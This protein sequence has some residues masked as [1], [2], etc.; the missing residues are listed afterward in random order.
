MTMISV[1]LADIVPKNGARIAYSFW[2][3]GK[4]SSP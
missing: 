4:R 2:V 3:R 1:Y